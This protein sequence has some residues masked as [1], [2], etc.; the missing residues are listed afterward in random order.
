MCNLSQ[1]I[2]N[3]GVEK[4]ITQGVEKGLVV[5]REEGRA[6]EREAAVKSLIEKMGWT[7]QQA[8]EALGY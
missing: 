8:K 2:Y 6:E 1:G 3:A 5:G 4:G 7:A